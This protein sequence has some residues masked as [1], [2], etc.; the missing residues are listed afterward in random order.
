MSDVVQSREM[1]SRSGG[2]VI[3]LP[4]GS[5]RTYDA[6]VTGA[7]IAASISRGLAKVAFAV[8]VNG[9]LMDLD[10]PISQ[11]ASVRLLKAE[12][13]EALP[14]IRHDCAHVMAEAVQ[15]LFPGTQV[16]IGPPID[17]G[18]Y[19]DFYRNE[20]FSSED[21]EKIEARMAE[22][23]AADKR[24][25]REEVSREEAHLRFDE[26]GERFKLELLDAIPEGE[27]VSIYHQG[28]W[29][30]LCRGP[31]G[32]STGRIGAF[33]LTKVAGAYWRGDARNPQLQRIYGTAFASK[34]QLDAY[35]H[36]LAEAERRDHRRLGREMDLF[37]FQEEAVG[38]CF[39]HPQGWT[40]WREI[41]NYVRR[42]LD[43][44]GYLEVK[45]PQLIDR[46]LWERSGH[47]EKF[48]ENMFTLEA[49]ERALAIKPM[50]CP[51]H[52]QIFNQTL[53]SY[54][55]LPLRLAEFG[56]CHR[57]EPS[58]A[59]HGL[60]RV[61]AFTQDDAHIFCTPEQITAETKAF[62][63]LLMSVYRDFGFEDVRI[64]FSDRPPV[65]A[66]SDAVWDQAENA[67]WEAVR[68]TGLEVSLN[69]GEGAFY[70]P[71][72][73][74]VLK[75]AIGRDWQCGTLQVDFVLPERLGADYVG[76]DGAKH[77]P[78]MLHRAI[79]GSMER[80]IGVLL[81][82]YAGRLPLWLAPVQIVV[83][84]VTNEADAYAYEV[85]GL[86]R[87]AGLRAEADTRSDKIGYKVREH[88]VKKVP[89]IFAVGQREA[90]ERTVSIRRL[91]SQE[92]KVLALDEAVTMCQ[93]ESAAPDIRAG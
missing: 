8:E 70:G 92:Q 48:R 35:L 53:H 2:V 49:E 12:D 54:R 84:T 32:P 45:T 16:T 31:H 18:F 61:R 62:C 3:T 69:P 51:G 17:N 56:S 10:R 1:T 30:D 83:A 74:F 76:Q 23:V 36:Q 19:Y 77:R 63:D 5:T 44:A 15:D 64:K 25:V 91:G 7:E 24:F 42:R 71:K 88:S 65:R 40:V 89:L 11:D 46:S 27:P 50:N 82:H 78:V 80:F 58:G 4:D 68:D 57:N 28:G 73:E 34:K 55:D 29:F 9:E 43:R 26:L 37:H 20:P 72:L 75:D 66:G 14:V 33:K 39:W 41:E 38:S 79:L 13:P 93:R 81:E 87:E 59:L 67:L 85:A 22:I 86:L 47:W 90:A 6:P 52:V 21:L 60:M